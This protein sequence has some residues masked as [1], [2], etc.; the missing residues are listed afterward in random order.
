MDDIENPVTYALEG[1]RAIKNSKA[2]KNL[3]TNL[4][5]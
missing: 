2:L 4:R 3:L 1:L 5:A